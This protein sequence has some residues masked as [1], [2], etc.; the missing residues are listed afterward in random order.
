M[1]AFHLR[2]LGSGCYDVSHGWTAPAIQRGEIP[3]VFFFLSTL[4]ASGQQI[5]PQ[6]TSLTEKAKPY[7]SLSMFDNARQ[8]LSAALAENEFDP[9][10]HFLMGQLWV[11]DKEWSKAAKEF[12][13]AYNIQPTALSAAGRMSVALAV[14]FGKNGEREFRV[15]AL[16]YARAYLR[17]P[18]QEG[19]D[20]F[21][22]AQSLTALDA[23]V[24][25]A[26]EL[27]LGV[28]GKWVT[29][30]GGNTFFRRREILSTKCFIL[31]MD[32]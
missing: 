5:A 31:S 20:P 32:K 23:D 4:V 21:E 12:R 28:S 15:D 9:L 10:A 11:A 25:A 19:A 17:R 13:I 18:R 27:L 8:A 29:G 7:I 2:R 22:S 1:F 16:Q 30:A 24:T 6:P 3:S 14:Q 26:Q